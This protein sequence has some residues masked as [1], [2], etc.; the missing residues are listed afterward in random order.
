MEVGEH[1]AWSAPEMWQ[2]VRP[3]P[4]CGLQTVHE[5]FIH[6]S[7]HRMKEAKTQGYHVPLHELCT[8]HVQRIVIYIILIEL[9]SL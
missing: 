6:G 7:P 1:F 4:I 8:V 3:C 9:C 5:S 2:E